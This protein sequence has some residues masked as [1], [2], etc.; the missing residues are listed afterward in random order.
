MKTIWSV[1][2]TEYAYD[3]DVHYFPTQRAAEFYAKERFGTF[4][5]GSTNSYVIDGWNVVVDSEVWSDQ[6]YSDLFPWVD[7]EYA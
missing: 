6:E 7:S 4:T 2:K 3:P 5:L 1:T